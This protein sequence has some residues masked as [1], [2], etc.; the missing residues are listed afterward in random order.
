MMK[1]TN[2]LRYP[3][4]S[5]K[6]EYLNTTEITS[7]GLRYDR[8]WALFNS[9]WQVITGRQYPQMLN[10]KVDIKDNNVT[11]ILDDQPQVTFKT[12]TINTT[13]IN[14]KIF[15][16][17][18][19]GISVGNNIDQ[20]FSEYLLQEVHMLYTA[21]QKRPVLSE[22]GGKKGD[23]I[24]FADQAPILLLSEESL[25]DL[26]RRLLA[27]ITF[28][29][30]RPNIVVSGCEAYAEDNWKEIKI[31]ECTFEVIQ[32]CE[33]CIFTTI[34]PK[35]KIKHPQKEPLKTLATYRKNINGGVDFGVHLV[36]KKLGEI[37]LS[38]EI[39]VI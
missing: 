37:H 24:S 8:N 32:K 31:G 11:V 6:G 29:R 18:I 12:N 5:C 2:I 13:T 27:P 20:W 16:Y 28:Q 4:K 22:H 14:A 1:V 21:D 7:K 38:E 15:S 33:R 39:N 3:I 10:I 23:I 25:T 19:A 17:D 34:D 30:F 36:P 26:N 35:T 9:K